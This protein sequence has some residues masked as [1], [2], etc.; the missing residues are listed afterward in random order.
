MHNIT[1][2]IRTE[3]QIKKELIEIKEEETLIFKELALFRTMD[4]PNILKFYE[5]Y[6]DEKFFSIICELV[7]LF[8]NT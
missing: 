5:F 1:G 8:K 4:H 3:K 7:S 2:R 6:K